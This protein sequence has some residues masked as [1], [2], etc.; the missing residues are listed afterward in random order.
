MFKHRKALGV[1]AALTFVFVLC[2]GAMAAT[3]NAYTIM[4]EKYASK[5]FAEFTK[6]TGIKVNFI[7]FSSGEA[8]ARLVAEKAN[9]Q[10]DV[11]LGGPAPTAVAA[12]DQPLCRRREQLRQSRRRRGALSARRGGSGQDRF[13]LHRVSQRPVNL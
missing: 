4:P 12:A 13:L 7:R 1:L 8:L 10:V 11:L 6:E 2:T 5:V 9:P 3:L